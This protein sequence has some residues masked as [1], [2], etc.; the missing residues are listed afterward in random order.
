M[1]S[2][3]ILSKGNEG[4]PLAI[5]FA[6]EGHICKVHTKDSNKGLLPSTSKNPTLISNPTRLLEQFDLV[7]CSSAGLGSMAEEFRDKG[8]LT[9]G[10]VFNDRLEED[11]EYVNAVAGVLLKTPLKIPDAAALPVST[12]GWFKDGSF[13]LLYHS[14]KYNKFMEH[15]KGYDVNMGCIV[16]PCK[17][18][19]LY[20]ETLKPLI[21]LL[22]KVKYQG[23]LTMN[24]VC[25]TDE[26]IF[27]DFNSSIDVSFYPYLELLK[28]TTFDLFFKQ[29][30]SQIRE[31][32]IAMSCVLSRPPWPYPIPTETGS[33]LVEDF[34]SIPEAAKSHA[35]ILPASNGI[36]GYIT[37]RGEGS[38]EARRRLY[39]TIN[40]SVLN[41][42]VQYRSDIGYG[43]EDKITTLKKWGWLDA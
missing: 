21:P 10:G 40:N 34:L 5:R 8:K 14:F 11:E 38:N 6:Q 41:N 26:K 7:I 25:F 29:N 3:L 19:K 33:S 9:Y 23:P 1:A 37:A 27:L 36:F 16:F 30:G 18:D 20:Q 4:I 22:T 12:T 43:F 24:V 35:F 31:Q 39:R 17:E 15:D 28:C 32:D 42:N 2:I 13:S